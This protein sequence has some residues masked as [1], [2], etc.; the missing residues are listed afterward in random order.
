MHQP[1]RTA[2]PEHTTHPACAV[3][4]SACPASTVALQ[5]GSAARQTSRYYLPLLLLFLLAAGGPG[6]P[7][8]F[9]AKRPLHFTEDLIIRYRFPRLHQI[10]NLRLLADLLSQLFLRHPLRLPRLHDAYLEILADLLVCKWARTQHTQRH[11]GSGPD[12]TR[13]FKPVLAGRL[14][15]LLR[16]LANRRVLAVATTAD[17]T[18]ER[19]GDSSARTAPHQVR[20]LLRVLLYCGWKRGGAAA[21]GLAATYVAR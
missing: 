10:D 21:R 8:Q 6:R 12:C 11:T 5:H 18:S 4:H 20:A 9:H 7:S 13:T 17:C 15:Q 19:G 3:I 1:F 14:I 16:L 2:E